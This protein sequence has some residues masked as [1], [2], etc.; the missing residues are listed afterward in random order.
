MAGVT[1][2]AVVAYWQNIHKPAPVMISQATRPPAPP[3]PI[4]G[5]LPA[6][7]VR[8][9]LDTPARQAA[10]EKALDKVATPQELRQTIVAQPPAQEKAKDAEPVPPP[11]KEESAPHPIGGVGGGG[12]RGAVSGFR[13]SDAVTV[14][15][16]ATPMASPPPPPAPAA[17]APKGAA[18]SGSFQAGQLNKQ[19]AATPA[20][21]QQTQ[22]QQGAAPAA[23]NQLQIQPLRAEQ[24]FALASPVG[25]AL[26]GRSAQTQFYGTSA[27][28][29]KK[30]TAD[31]V[32]AN[33][34]G[35]SGNS[36]SA[37]TRLAAAPPSSNL[38]VRYSIQRAKADGGVETVDPKN[39]VPGETL[40]VQ[41][42]PNH[43]GA[44]TVKARSG[45]G[46]WRELIS[47]N[48]EA[49]QSYPTPPLAAGESELQVTLL[50][51]ANVALRDDRNTVGVTHQTT[52]E[53]A[54]YV[55]TNQAA[56][57]LQFS[58]RLR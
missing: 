48:V 20:P 34:P 13:E 23:Q 43:A 53:P 22:G 1:I 26:A 50:T 49:M 47:L 30:K 40:T 46:P 38:G 33:R 58:I 44:L 54:T 24:A 6:N 10:N 3:F 2:L 12:G 27:D 16:S 21:N 45:T 9:P 17:A 35:F 4:P 28:D 57:Q 25:E 41:F 19:Q 7:E 18:E 29:A 56:Q 37:R 36:I 5:S 31:A 51:A 11:V 42:M 8:V 32:S 14:N 15:G 52:P 55:V 39:V